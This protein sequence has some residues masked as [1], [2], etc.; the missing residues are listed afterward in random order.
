MST[1]KLIE[2]ANIFHVHQGL[3]DGNLSNRKLVRRSI[4][5]SGVIFHQNVVDAGV[6]IAASNL[7]GVIKHPQD[8]LGNNAVKLLNVF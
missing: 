6:D 2:V 5:R 4:T 7:F 1:P 8:M 3:T